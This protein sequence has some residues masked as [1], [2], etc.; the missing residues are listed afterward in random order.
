MTLFDILTKL[1][2][3][4]DLE[5]EKETKENEKTWKFASGHKRQQIW[6]AYF[7]SEEFVNVYCVDF[8]EISICKSLIFFSFLH[9]CLSHFIS[10]ALRYNLIVQRTEMYD[11]VEAFHFVITNY[12]NK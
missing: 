5:I 9:M 7:P 1:F 10:P 8:L 11:I 2:S 6:L 4:Q 3:H 12:S